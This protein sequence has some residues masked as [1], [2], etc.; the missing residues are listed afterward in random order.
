MQCNRGTCPIRGP[1]KMQTKVYIARRKERVLALAS[2]M[3][4]TKEKRETKHRVL[5]LI[6][7]PIAPRLHL[8]N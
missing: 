3:L 8:F 6:F 4:A 1:T 7:Y 2:A 5:Y